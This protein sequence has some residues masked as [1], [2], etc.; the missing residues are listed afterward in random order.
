LKKLIR[1]GGLSFRVGVG[2]K[3]RRR[4]TIPQWNSLSEP[5]FEEK[6]KTH[7]STGK[8]E[9]SQAGGRQRINHASGKEG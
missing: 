6:K 5:I 4:G 2:M 7:P 1:P 3:S 9:S 8:Y